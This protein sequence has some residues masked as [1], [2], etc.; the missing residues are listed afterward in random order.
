MDDYSSSH[1]PEISQTP[2]H[3]THEAADEVSRA[4]EVYDGGLRGLA[5]QVDDAV[6]AV[7]HVGG[8]GALVVAEK[9]RNYFIS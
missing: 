8:G 9:A 6:N 1:A 7:G 3:A 5:V 4:A 2:G